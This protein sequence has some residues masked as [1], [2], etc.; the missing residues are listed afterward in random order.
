[1]VIIWMLGI[2]DFFYYGGNNNNADDAAT[3]EF[4]NDQLQRLLQ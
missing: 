3:V 2:L 1:M 4:S